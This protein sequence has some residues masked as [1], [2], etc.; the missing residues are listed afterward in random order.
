M[1][2]T[3]NQTPSE[4]L[5]VPLFCDLP[6][7]YIPWTTGSCRN[8]PKGTRYGRRAFMQIG[9]VLILGWCFQNCWK[10]NHTYNSKMHD[11]SLTTINSSLGRFGSSS[12][13]YIYIY[14]FMIDWAFKTTEATSQ[15]P[16]H[17]QNTTK[18]TYVQ[19]HHRHRDS[20]VPG[21]VH[22]AVPV[23]IISVGWLAVFT[24]MMQPSSCASCLLSCSKRHHLRF[25]G[26]VSTTEGTC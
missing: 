7:S 9:Q 14:K 19:K 25:Q 8:K 17:H 10:I 26:K 18:T 2:Q 20:P 11:V 23:V 16:K 24:V 3:T 13:I 6:Q 21:W 4:A 15:A 5:P 1:F 12:H 22:T